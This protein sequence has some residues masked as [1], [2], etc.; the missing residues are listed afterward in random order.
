MRNCIVARAIGGLRRGA[1]GRRR[2]PDEC[3]SQENPNSCP[4]A[5]KR[6]DGR[7]GGRGG[8][9]GIR[10]SD[11]GI[12]RFLK[13]GP[14]LHLTN[15]LNLCILYE[16][17]PSVACLPVHACRVLLGDSQRRGHRSKEA[18]SARRYSLGLPANSSLFD[19]QNPAHS[20]MCSIAGRLSA[21]WHSKI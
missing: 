11:F 7:R 13:P 19:I 18:R 1:S 14:H 17:R 20:A 2:T 15:Y 3:L 10:H 12:R 16:Q 9:I 4:A 6:G 8:S 5:A 21:S